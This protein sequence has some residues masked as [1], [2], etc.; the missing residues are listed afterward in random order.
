MNKINGSIEPEYNPIFGRLVN[1]EGPEVEQLSGLVAY[2]LYKVAKREWAADLRRR[3]QRGPTPEELHAYILTWTE[4]RIRGLEEQ[5][6]SVLGNFATSV[7]EDNTPKIREDALKGTST[8]AIVLSIVANALY[9]L[10]LIGILII[11]RVSGVDLL[12]I[13]GALSGK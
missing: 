6:E 9:T 4:S 3:H 13:L 12:S 1:S 8:R 5:A 10:L 2:G 7:V 11:L